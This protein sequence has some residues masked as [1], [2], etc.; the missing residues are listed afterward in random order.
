MINRKRIRNLQLYIRGFA[1]GEPVNCAVRVTDDLRVRL[2][3]AGFTSELAAGE[4]VLPTVLGPTSRFNAEGRLYPQRDQPKETAYRTVEWTRVEFHGKDRVEVTELRDIPYQRYPRTFVEPPSI[5][6]LL[7]C[8]EQGSLLVTAPAVPYVDEAHKLLLHTINLL[9]ELF[10]SCELLNA[11]LT[12]A[13]P[14]PTVKRLNWKVLPQ[15]VMPWEQLRT[16]LEPMVDRSR[17]SARPFLEQRLRMLH[18]FRPD[19]QVLGEAGFGGYVIFGFSTRKLFVCE[20]AIYGNAT[21]VFGEN[22]ERLSQFSKAEILNGSLERARIIHVLS[23]ET[24]LR[25]LLGT[26]GNH[27]AEEG[28]S[29]H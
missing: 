18:R 24:H 13:P 3:K 2:E 6:L 26:P 28:G 19:F 10:G 12:A 17:S 20:C 27:T 21:Y 4:T 25:E 8:D 16:A 9:L 22:W 11:E 1:D 14:P 29:D 5:E 7:R 23:W 15:G